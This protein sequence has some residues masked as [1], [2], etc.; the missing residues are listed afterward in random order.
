MYDIYVICDRVT[1]VW[2]FTVLAVA[3]SSSVDIQ[4]CVSCM[5][6]ILPP[7]FD[8]KINIGYETRRIVLL[9][10]EPRIQRLKFRQEILTLASVQLALEGEDTAPCLSINFHDQCHVSTH[11]SGGKSYRHTKIMTADY[12]TS[13]Q[14]RCTIAKIVSRR[15]LRR[16][17][18]P[19]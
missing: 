12:F 4:C 2:L 1:R 17:P 8:G 3:Q 19:D 6:T 14:G 13:R 7:N 18:V 10:L 11:D 5:S 16:A 9:T 15:L